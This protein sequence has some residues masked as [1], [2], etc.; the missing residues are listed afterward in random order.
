VA[1]AE[2]N[3]RGISA[4]ISSVQFARD[5]SLPGS[6]MELPPPPPPQCCQAGR[7]V[8]GCTTDGAPP[9][10]AGGIPLD[11]SYEIDPTGLCSADAGLLDA[12]DEIPG[13]T[14][15]CRTPEVCTQ[16]DGGWQCCASVGPTRSIQVCLAP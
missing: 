10:Y 2:I 1:N 12:G 14:R 4:W 13:V 5:I 7:C 8:T 9:P 3:V 15:W 6:C 11:A 16:T